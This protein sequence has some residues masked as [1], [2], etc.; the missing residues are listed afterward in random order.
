MAGIYSAPGASFNY[1]SVSSSF[2]TFDLNST[3]GHQFFTRRTLI[4]TSNELRTEVF[5]VVDEN[6]AGL[7]SDESIYGGTFAVARDN[8]PGDAT[9]L[10]ASILQGQFPN[11]AGIILE[12]YNYQDALGDLVSYSNWRDDLTGYLSQFVTRDRNGV[13]IITPAHQTNFDFNHFLTNIPEAQRIV[14]LPPDVNPN[15]TIWNFN[16]SYGQDPF[17]Q[18]LALYFTFEAYIG[19]ARIRA[20]GNFLEY[21][22]PIGS[23]NKGDPIVHT[24]PAGQTL[25]FFFQPEFGQC[26]SFSI[27]D[28][29][30]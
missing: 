1:D 16:R 23:T 13:P 10:G 19:K 18:G 6:L 26:Q 20:S 7:V 29:P 9:A 3:P 4:R 28:I 5:E 15:F 14:S 25:T 21:R 17:A 22:Y 24:V 27:P 12:E 8:L 2:T 11:A 30:P